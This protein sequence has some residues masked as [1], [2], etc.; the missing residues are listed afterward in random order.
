MKKQILFIVFL[1]AQLFCNITIA[2]AQ[3]NTYKVG[4]FY[5]DDDK[6]GVVFWVD[7]SGQ[8]GKIVSLEESP[9]LAWATDGYE[10]GN[11]SQTYNKEN[12]AVN[13]M[14]IQIDGGWKRKFP[15]FA[16][17]AELGD[18]W[19]IP[20]IEEL[21]MFTLNKEVYEAVSNTLFECFQ[22]GATPLA[23]GGEYGYWSSTEVEAMVIAEV[24]D[25]VE[26]DR[27]S[28]SPKHPEIPVVRMGTNN[29][30]HE[31][32]FPKY[33]EFCVRAVA[34]FGPRPET[35]VVMPLGY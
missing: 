8:R 2:S 18:E 5:C 20:A 16:W 15:A 12:G 33:H 26:V 9:R 11:T 30:W 10:I 13:M 3:K 27:D 7:E 28:S 22:L 23:N 1:C 17:C 31:W 35:M 29:S 4:D 19:Y 25:G 32:S 34:T 6:M 14:M 24:V 21:K